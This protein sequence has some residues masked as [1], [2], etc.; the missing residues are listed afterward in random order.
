MLGSASIII[1]EAN[2][3]APSIA[4]MHISRT[5]TVFLRIILF[6]ILFPYKLIVVAI[7]N[8]SAVNTDEHHFTILVEAPV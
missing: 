1:L 6:C 2:I 8:R 3:T 4:K 5:F 7:G